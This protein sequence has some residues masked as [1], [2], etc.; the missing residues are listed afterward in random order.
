MFGKLRDFL[1]K[2]APHQVAQARAAI[3]QVAPSV[4]KVLPSLQQVTPALTPPTQDVAAVP[5]A[6]PK[7]QPFGGFGKTMGDSS[8]ITQS[9]AN[10][11]APAM[12]GGF[13]KLMTR[14]RGRK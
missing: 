1:T 9:I 7:A 12:R 4:E 5:T 10:V 14:F 2:T 11:A 3:Q 8:G 6:I 13:S